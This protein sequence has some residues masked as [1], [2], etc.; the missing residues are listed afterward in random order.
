MEQKVESQSLKAQPQYRIEREIIVEPHPHEGTPRRPSALRWVLGLTTALLLGL[1]TYRFLTSPH[2]AGQEVAHAGRTAPQPVGITTVSRGDIRIALNALGTVTPLAMV[3]VKP[4]VSGQLVAVGFKE[5]Q[6]IRKGD[7]LAEID[8]RP[9]EAAEAQYEG[10]L[11]RDQAQLRGAQVDL[12]RYQTLADKNAGT[13]QQADDQFYLVQQYQGTVKVDQ[14]QIDAQKINLA[15]CHIV[16]P[17]DGRVG[18]RQVDP[19]NYVQT[20]DPNGIV[21]ITQMQ[22]ISVIF[23]LAEGDLGPVLAQLR[24]GK[25]LQVTALDR[26][27]VQQIATGTLT[28]LDNQIDTTT[29]TVKLRAQFD[30]ADEKLFPNQFVNVNLLVET[31]PNVVTVPVA[32][33][34]HGAPGTFVYLVGADNTVT[35]RTVK[36]GPTDGDKAEVDEGLSPGDRVV[37]DGTDHLRDGATVAAVAQDGPAKESDANPQSPAVSDGTPGGDPQLRRGGHRR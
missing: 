14:A 35:V 32:A 11:E 25:Q 36:L 8:S 2:E 15:N 5:G 12:V 20:G 6:D 4:Q 3:T 26:G 30:N 16:A 1:G 37:I 33:I 17:I 18:L 27:G 31:R 24:A 7:F 19:G 9:F 34:Q 23:S 28:T 13:R 29:G 22:P 10:Q 21:V